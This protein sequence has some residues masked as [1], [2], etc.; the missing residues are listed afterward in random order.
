MRDLFSATTQQNTFYADNGWGSGLPWLYY[1]RT[2]SQVI[3]QRNRIK[4]K[5]TLDTNEAD[6][7]RYAYV[8]L[9]LA[10]YALDGE[11]IGWEDLSTQLHMCEVTQDD[12]KRY[13][14]VGLGLAKT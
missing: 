2:G 10:K 13:R 6:S 14:R 1:E 7:S 12:S 3:Y 9:K 4:A 5:L 8:P 11:F